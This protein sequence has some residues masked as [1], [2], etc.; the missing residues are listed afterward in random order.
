MKVL[1]EEKARAEGWGVHE[2]DAS[3]N[4]FITIPEET[5]ALLERI[6]A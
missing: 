1:L 4:P 5:M 3:H 6:V 2:L